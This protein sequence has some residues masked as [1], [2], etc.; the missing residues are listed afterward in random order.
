M[1]GPTAG[2][3][4]VLSFL[5]WTE[6]ER[7]VVHH[8]NSWLVL[9]VIKS[10]GTLSVS[11]PPHALCNHGYSPS[12]LARMASAVAMMGRWADPL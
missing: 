2:V 4:D 11:C 1:E 9:G 12:A 5:W 10:E 7:V 8:A 6:V 3:D